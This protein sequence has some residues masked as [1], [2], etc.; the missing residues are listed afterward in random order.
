MA[1]GEIRVDPGFIS[2]LESRYR[3]IAGALREV[4]S[5]PA[6]LHQSPPVQSAFEDF[7]GRWDWTRGKLAD[8][9]DG[10]ADAIGTAGAAFIEADAKMAATLDGS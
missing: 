1:A 6:S 7:Q 3:G 10:L 9:A 4:K 5:A 2:D 8:A